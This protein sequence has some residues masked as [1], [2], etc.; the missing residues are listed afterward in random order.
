[1][2]GGKERVVNGYSRVGSIADRQEPNRE[3]NS[4]TTS[5]FW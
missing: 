1:M 5:S 2:G 3:L 4:L